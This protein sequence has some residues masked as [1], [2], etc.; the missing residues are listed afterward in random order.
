MLCSNSGS[1][2]S[3]SIMLLRS[4][5]RVLA[6]HQDHRITQNHKIRPA[7]RPFHGIVRFCIS[8]IEVCSQ[9]RCQMSPRRKTHDPN[10]SGVHVPFRR[11]AAYS[12]AS[13]VERLPEAPDTDIPFHRADNPAQTRSPPNP[14]NQCATVV[15]S[16]SIDKC[17]YPPPG[18]TIIPVP[19]GLLL[20]RRIN[21][22]IRFV[23]IGISLG[24]G[25]RRSATT[26]PSSAQHPIA[27][28]PSPTRPRP[29]PSTGTDSAISLSHFSFLR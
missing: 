22:Q 26:K 9:R 28:I 14:F 3:P 19:A 10:S 6:V 20:R 25:A 13:R 16:F 2:L 24:V 1:G 11:L 27:S 23:L 17:S 15:P 5:V 8:L 12:I 18:Q 4:F 7:T 21:R 29:P